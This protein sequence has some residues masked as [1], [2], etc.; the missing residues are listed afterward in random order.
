MVGKNEKHWSPRSIS[1]IQQSGVNWRVFLWCVE[2]MKGLRCLKGQQDAIQWSDPAVPVRLIS[3]KHSWNSGLVIITVTKFWGL[4]SCLRMLLKC[5]NIE[6]QIG[7]GGFWRRW[8]QWS[9]NQAGRSRRLG[10]AY[11]GSQDGTKTLRMNEQS[12][13]G[14]QGGLQPL[15]PVCVDGKEANQQYTTAC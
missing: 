15:S 9:R 1:L 8:A 3:W 5:W 13:Q 12:T 4:L 7:S 11:S 10:P 6:T 2:I 14:R